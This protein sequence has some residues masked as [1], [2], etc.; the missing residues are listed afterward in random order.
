MGITSFSFLCFYAVVLILYYILPKKQQWILLLIASVAYFVLAVKSPLLL[1][2]P[3]VASLICFLGVL[4]MEKYPSR[5]KT[6]LCLGVLLTL[7]SLVLLKYANFGVYTYNAT[8][9]RITGNFLEPLAFLLPLGISFYTF[10]VLGYLLD[11]YYGI[12]KIQRNYFKFLLYGI[13]FPVMISG[14]LLRYKEDGE[15]FFAGHSFDY[16]NITF[17]MQRMVWGF[18]KKLVISE[19][20]AV[21]VNTVYGQYT[22]YSGFYIWLAAAAFVLQLYTDFSGCMDIVLGLSESFGIRLPENFHLPFSSASI[23]EFWRRW[24]MTLGVWMKDYVFYPILR[25]GCFQK[26]GTWAKSHY[27]KK[28]AK[29]IPTYLGMLI[30]WFTVGLWHGGAWKFIVG[31]GLLHCAYIILGELIKP[32]FDRWFEKHSI[33]PKA[34]WLYRLRQ[35]RTFAL[36]A[37]SFIFFRADSFLEGLA[38]VKSGF[39]APAEAALAAGGV[40][41]LGLDRIELLVLILCLVVLTAVSRLQKSIKIRERLADKKLPVRWCIY[42]ALLFAVILWGYYG[43]GYSAAEFIYQ[44]F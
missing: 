34:G 33:D 18:F 3:V 39:F 38:I 12:G 41:G 44:G 31:S 9:G 22:S 7:S 27:G 6:V 13:Y 29:R 2:Y 19:R 5:K 43:P 10:S 15:Q 8:A 35:I 37:F 42:Y 25:S 24:H 36:V 26:L 1:L 11:G 16:Q 21:I 14:P 4:L 17:G 40:M 30:L 20:L 32:F 23:A 28:A